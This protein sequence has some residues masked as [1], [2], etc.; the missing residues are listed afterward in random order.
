MTESIFIKKSFQGGLMFAQ[1]GY[2]GFGI[3][4]DV[5]SLYPSIMN[6]NE[7]QIPVKAGEPMFISQ[8]EFQ[9]L[10]YFK[11]G[12]YHVEIEQSDTKLFRFSKRNWYTHFDLTL[13]KEL[14]L[15]MKILCDE[16]YKSCNFFYYSLDKLVKS[17]YIFGNFVEKLYELK[18]QNKSFK[19]LLSSLWGSLCERK[20]Y[21]KIITVHEEF[22]IP[23]TGE[24]LEIVPV[25]A[26]IKVKYLPD[27]TTLYKR[28]EARLGTFLT[29][30][31]RMHVARQLIP[32]EKHIVR[33]HTD[34]VV[35]DQDIDTKFKIDGEIG[36]WKLEYKT[37]IEVEHVNCVEM[38]NS[39]SGNV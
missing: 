23:E 21:K 39:I 38:P 25:G 11:Y 14:G 3:S 26:D 1:Q 18:T 34:G 12:I 9:S 32:H 35:F 27:K 16:S 2:K 19:K 22:E 7:F 31:A 30:Y 33:L 20:V 28:N 8:E 6:K 5:N 4:Y 13:A 15:N 24:I 17:K 36:S 37:E 10:K 29:A